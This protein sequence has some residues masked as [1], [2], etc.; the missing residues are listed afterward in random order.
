MNLKKKPFSKK[1][2][3]L[4]I[5]LPGLLLVKIFLTIEGAASG[6]SLLDLEREESL[7]VK[8]NRL[9]EVDLDKL[10]SLTNIGNEAKSFGFDVP[11]KIFYLGNEESVAKIP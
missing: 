10:S 9:L 11:Y 1:N 2:I 6:E 7:F 8:D 5:I 3:I 4:W